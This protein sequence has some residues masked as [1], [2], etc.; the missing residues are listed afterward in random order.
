MAEVSKTLRRAPALLTLLWVFSAGSL[1]AQTATPTQTP[2]PLP[3][4]MT[5][6]WG[7][8]GSGDGQLHDPREFAIVG[9]TLYVDDMQ[10]S[11]IER[12]T[13]DGALILPHLTAGGTL[14]H[15]FGLT[16][17]PSGMLFVSESG[18]NA[19]RIIKLDPATDQ[20]A[21]T[22][23][24]GNSRY[25]GL[26]LDTDGD[27]YVALND[28]ATAAVCMEK[29][30]ETSPAT[31]NLVGSYSNWSFANGVLPI[32][33]GVTVYLADTG[34]SLVIRLL[35]TPPGSDHYVFDRNVLTPGHGAPG[36]DA[37]VYP[38]QMAV[39][40]NGFFYLTDLTDRIQVYDSGWN[41]RYACDSAVVGTYG[42][43]L[44]GS[45]NIFEGIGQ[46]VVRIQAGVMPAAW[47]PPAATATPTQVPCGGKPQTAY[48]YP[49]PLRAG[50]GHL[51]IVL[52]K[53][54]NVKVVFY[55]ALGDLAGKADYAGVG[56]DNR[57]DFDFTDFTPG[58]YY[59]LV[60]VDGNRQAPGK[61]AVTR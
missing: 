15:P 14:I 33:N 49:S 9:S 23:T 31:W 36:I 46:W 27:L 56:G 26:G 41:F 7:G 2:W 18:S 48:L 59:Y 3:C 1:G 22:I 51:G 17:D 44:D 24:S 53:A 32:S 28:P 20:V 58:I 29:Y 61:F 60:E 37:T 50:M 55:N 42:L 45:G 5:A 54:G 34:N 43:A 8:L 16:A 30:R 47:V 21:A 38:H 39:D 19:C 57:F 40:G 11:R 25:A 10:N 6:Q 13:L 52:C 35:E 12:F 4:A